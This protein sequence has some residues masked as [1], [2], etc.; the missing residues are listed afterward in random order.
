MLKKLLILLFALILFVLIG[1]LAFFGPYYARV[2]Y[3][4]PNPAKGYHAG[5]Y[6]YISPGAKKTGLQ[7]GPVTL[8]VQ[9]NNTG[10]ISDNAKVHQKGAWMTGFE[11]HK[12]ANDL[13]VV[14]LVPAFI[15]PA[16]DWH[17]YTQALDRDA[18]VTKR[19]D[20]I[21]IDLQLLA[22]IDEARALLKEDGIESNEKF[23]LQGFSASGMFANRFTILHPE[24]VLAVVAGSPGG[25]PIAPVNYYKEVLL[26][27][28]AGIGDLEVLTGKAFDSL[29]YVGIPQLI[30]MGSA[31]DNDSL[32]FTDGW[33][34]EAASIVDGFFGKDPLS[35][36]PHAEALYR[37]AGAKVKFVLVEGVG[38]DRKKLQSYGVEF[39]ADILNPQNPD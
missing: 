7:G 33:D 1:I 37:Q 29:S 39:F 6:L 12:I 5:F 34:K 18:V 35:R 22:M 14:L 9:P 8:L 30:I 15:R 23:L 11:R 17:I 13:N 25:W 38:H 27:Y 28:P 20:L 10:T 24:K 21:R 3:H 36:W 31:D 16:E 19:K 4:A 32:D 2:N 26:A